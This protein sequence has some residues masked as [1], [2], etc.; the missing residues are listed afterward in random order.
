M[1]LL[2]STAMPTATIAF[3]SVPYGTFDSNAKGPCLAPRLHGSRPPA[4][5]GRRLQWRWFS[6]YRIL[7]R[8]RGRKPRESC[9]V[10]ATEPSPHR[11]PLPAHYSTLR[12]FLATS[13]TTANWI[14][15]VIGPIGPPPA[16]QGSF[17]AGNGDGTF[18][19]PVSPQ[20]Q[21]GASILRRWPP[22]WTGMATPMSSVGNFGRDV[23]PTVNVFGNNK[24]GTFGVAS[25]DTFDAQ[26][27]GRGGSCGKFHRSVDTRRQLLRQRE[28]GLRRAGH[29][30]DAG[31]FHLAEH[32][33]SGRI[34]LGSGGEDALSGACGSD[35]GQ[36]H[37]QRFFRSG[38]ANGTTIS[39]L[40]NDGTG[41]FTASYTTLTVASTS[42]SLP[43][44]MRTAMVTR[45]FIWR[46]SKTGSRR[47]A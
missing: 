39:V 9:W 28:P 23:A 14:I 2:P 36:L 38:V 16:P 26:C 13:I 17:F 25:Q 34:F 40:A 47:S 24:D 31:H 30:R 7:L 15:A 46:P 8:R 10:T 18:A 3:G 6:R 1:S 33:F 4:R 45:T 11:Q 35:G 42:R 43:S 32:Q 20:F 29:R 21:A 27:L 37:R 19:A 12:R 22:M 5:S 44:R 41:T